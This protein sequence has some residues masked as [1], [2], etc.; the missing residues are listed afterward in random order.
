MALLAGSK[1]FGG[2]YI[3]FGVHGGLHYDVGNLANEG[4]DVTYEGQNNL[5]MGVSAKFDRD[6]LFMRTGADRSVVM[7]KGKVVNSSDGKL[8]QTKISY[9]SIP[10][11]MG[12][13]FRIREKGKFYMGA[14]LAYI[15]GSGTVKTTDGTTRV[16]GNLFG[17]GFIT[18]VQLRVGN[19]IQVYTEWEYI[20][21]RTR[22]RVAR[23]AANTWKDFSIDYSGHRMHLGLSYYIL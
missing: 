18:G 4:S 17:L 1:I 21:A 11:Y 16:E 3:G 8:E 15:L 7:T 12:L 14:G 10:A 23:D 9:T 6:P 22:P 2:E 5:I 19:A 13:N 20:S